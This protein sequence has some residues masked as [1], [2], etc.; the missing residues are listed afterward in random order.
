M[1]FCS[2]FSNIFLMFQCFFFQLGIL[3]PCKR[4]YYLLSLYTY[5]H[6]DSVFKTWLK[7]FSYFLAVSQILNFGKPSIFKEVMAISRF[8]YFLAVSQI[9]NF[10]NPSTFNKVMAI[11]RFS[12][13][14]AVSQ[15]LNF[16]N[17]SIFNKVMAIS[18]LN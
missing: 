6:S 13:F 4:I 9:L 1:L 16:E 18:S 8:S 10:E 11:S 15:I 5:G 12:Y 2:Y 17:P 3:F 14:L 7:R